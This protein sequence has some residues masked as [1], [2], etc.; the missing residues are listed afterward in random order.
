MT[1]SWV[2][3]SFD[4]T[5]TADGADGAAFGIYCYPN[6]N[7][8]DVDYIA[9]YDITD[10]IAIDA[11]ASATQTLTQRVTQT[12]KDIT[13][14]AAATTAVSSNLTAALADID[15]KMAGN[16]VAN[17]GF[18]RGLDSWTQGSTT[19]ATVIDAQSPHSG[20]RILKLSAHNSA[21]DTIA[22]KY[23]IPIQ[24]GRTYK[25]GGWIRADGNAEMPSTAQGNNKIRMGIT[26]QTNPVIEV[27]FDP[28]NY[29]TGSQWT[30]ISKTWK[31]TATT[32]A[33]VS[34]MALLS[35]GNL[36]VDDLYLLD[37]TD[38]VDIAA[39]A[40]G[41]S[42]IQTTVKNQ[43]DLIS[44]QADAVTQV[45]ADLGTVSQKSLNPFIDGSF[46]S[47]A[48]NQRIAG[49]QFIATT[50][51][52][53]CRVAYHKAGRNDRRKRPGDVERL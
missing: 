47:Y 50:Q 7:T 12:E 6:A 39:N 31:A 48:D 27:Q 51:A 38:S 28:K 1:T 25:L 41:I 43:G 5:T 29:Q 44:A 36:Y 9:L 14:N 3:Y 45:K 10:A 22:Q 24:K 19:V 17:G 52:R 4:F 8:I 26:G 34:F 16:L 15:N 30:E 20:G 49:A 11:N 32:F 33:Q 18:E 35:K 23:D 46:E 13:A 40:A 2:V 37:V 42:T 53:R 21:Q